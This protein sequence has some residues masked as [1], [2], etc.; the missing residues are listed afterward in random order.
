MITF[1]RHR[2]MGVRMMLNGH[3]RKG[4]LLGLSDFKS[5]ELFW[6][7]WWT[8]A[9]SFLEGI[10]INCSRKPLHHWFSISSDTW[11]TIWQVLFIS[12]AVTCRYSSLNVVTL[13]DGE[14]RGQKG[15]NVREY[16]MWSCIL[17]RSICLLV[18]VKGNF[19][20]LFGLFD[21]IFYGLV[22][23]IQMF[24]YW[25]MYI[26]PVVIFRDH[27]KSLC[28]QRKWTQYIKLLWGTYHP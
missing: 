4:C 13:W 3:Q 16:Y 6:A 27:M 28:M 19:F 7:Q 5:D 17:F 26:L 1:W 24:G 14:S 23:I 20:L 15:E 8:S 25:Y 9:G 18:T 2:H 11:R 12:F 22:W 10:T 21:V